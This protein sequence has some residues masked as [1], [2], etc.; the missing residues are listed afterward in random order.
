MYY[1]L[2]D[3]VTCLRCL[4]NNNFVFLECYKCN[5][6]ILI[7]FQDNSYKTFKDTSRQLKPYL[8][9]SFRLLRASANENSFLLRQYK[10]SRA[11]TRKTRII[12]LI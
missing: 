5:E 8:K 10:T 12:N 4:K 9:I 3:Q 2:L 6:L 1:F 7:T 11:K